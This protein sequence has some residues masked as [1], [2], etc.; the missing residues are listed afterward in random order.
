MDER[1]N[2][3]K[4]VSIYTFDELANILNIMINEFFPVVLPNIILFDIAILDLLL[5]SPEYK[6]LLLAIDNC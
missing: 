5:V 2:K 6:F 1:G 3:S 4:I